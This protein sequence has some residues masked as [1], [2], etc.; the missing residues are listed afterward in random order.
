MTRPAEFTVAVADWG[1]DG[2]AIRAV[3]EAVFI[4]EQGVPAEMEW[5]EDDPV[6]THL[7]ARSDTGEPI[8]TARLLP[9]GHVGR[10]AVVQAWRGRGVGAALLNRVLAIAGERGWKELRLHA[11][12]HAIPFYRRFGFVATGPEF[13]EAG[14]AHRAM[15]L[16]L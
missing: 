2:D 13:M 11:Q 9:D 7:L 5:D 8:G 12:V 10:M 1:A 16:C 3:R 15:S 4:R 6:S 14:I